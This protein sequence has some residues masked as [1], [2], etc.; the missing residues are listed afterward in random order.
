MIS[1]VCPKLKSNTLGSRT[2]NN[3]NSSPQ[4]GDIWVR[5][6]ISAESTSTGS[7][8]I[9]RD[10]G[11][12]RARFK[13]RVLTG[14]GLLSLGLPALSLNASGDSPPSISGGRFYFVEME[15][16]GAKGKTAGKLPIKGRRSEVRWDDENAWIRLFVPGSDEKPG[17]DPILRAVS[18]A[19][20]H[21]RRK[22]L[23]VRFRI[24]SCS[25]TNRDEPAEML[26]ETAVEL[27]RLL[28][29]GAPRLLELPLISI[30][31]PVDEDVGVMTLE[32]RFDRLR[33]RRESKEN[34]QFVEAAENL[35]AETTS[36]LILIGQSTQGDGT[37]ATLENDAK[38]AAKLKGGGLSPV[39]MFPS[40]AAA[41]ATV[42]AGLAHR[43]SMG[44]VA[45][46]G[47][48]AKRLGVLYEDDRD[49]VRCSWPMTNKAFERERASLRFSSGFDKSRR[50]S[51]PGPG[52]GEFVENLNLDPWSMEQLESLREGWR[53][54][55]LADRSNYQ[56]SHRAADAAFVTE[57]FINRA[58]SVTSVVSPFIGNSSDRRPSFNTMGDRRPSQAQM[59]DRKP[60]F[61]TMGN[62]SSMH[63]LR[64]SNAT[65][66]S[67]ER[68]PS[69]NTV[70][71]TPTNSAILQS[72]FFG[73]AAA[74]AMRTNGGGGSATP[75]LGH[76][77]PRARV[78]FELGGTKYDVSAYLEDHPK[79]KAFVDSV[80][81]RVGKMA[82]L[83][84]TSSL[85]AA[86]SDSNLNAEDSSPKKLLRGNVSPMKSGNKSLASSFNK[87]ARPG[88]GGFRLDNEVDPLPKG[89]ISPSKKSQQTGAPKYERNWCKRKVAM[90]TGG[91]SGVGAAV[92]D[93][94]CARGVK[95]LI[96]LC[97]N[98][99]TGRLKA[100]ELTE[101]HRNLEVDVVYCDLS[102]VKE[103]NNAVEQI[104]DLFAPD[105]K[106]DMLILCA[107][108][109]NKDE[110][111]KKEFE[112]TFAV[113]Y[114][115]NF[116]LVHAL[117]SLIDRPND[118]STECR[119]IF[120]GCAAVPPLGNSVDVDDLQ[121]EKSGVGPLG[122]GQYIHTKTMMFCFASELAR[123]LQD[124]G[125]RVTANVF[126]PGAVKSKLA[127]DVL[128]A[129]NPV[130]AR[131]ADAVYGLTEGV[132]V[133]SPAQGASLCVN[134]CSA[135][136]L[137]GVNGMV[138]HSGLTGNVTDF[139]PHPQ[140]GIATNKEVCRKLWAVT[141]KMLNV[142]LGKDS[143]VAEW[144]E[145][146]RPQRRQHQARAAYEN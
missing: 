102:S 146:F 48:S 91:T 21:G 68:Q 129:F 85:H 81:A 74:A 22:V 36:L 43:P 15:L 139:A 110:T 14:S 38:L 121:G 144:W 32:T 16:G 63:E 108:T 140:F 52:E 136:N 75:N 78:M 131:L 50:L 11:G 84:K 112:E 4:G 54:W 143:H 12:N 79:Q 46:F 61:N 142:A 8:T 101:K 31:D 113:N 118:A 97:R 86:L 69:F 135:D 55:Q 141:G 89:P 29:V 1:V 53:M 92:A 13:S 94:I 130:V 28:G 39:M 123:R 58:N 18:Q 5:K 103:T 73:T 66:N 116:L 128:I 37:N 25:S 33:P 114:M 99:N 24:M 137:N 40:A 117:F 71:G 95:R 82:L 7:P 2:T 20:G 60:S 30:S 100:R 115:S 127:D 122:L 67:D 27:D 132:F 44:N 3:N 87:G 83:E 59:G 10:K 111:K 119:I 35:A 45:A 105:E 42:A 124:R 77:T 125:G 26:L 145:I 134:L 107:A 138:F 64:S 104:K 98:L 47:A 19:A 96:L 51:C 88:D 90:I 133:R 120:A 70:W 106:L 109:V 126:F 9:S 41:L 49:L 56:P 72:P 93:E 23:V 57:R 62:N 34:L 80:S 76:Q 17:A 65:S 6:K